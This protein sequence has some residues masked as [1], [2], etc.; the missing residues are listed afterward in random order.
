MILQ[1]RTSSWAQLNNKQTYR[2]TYWLFNVNL[3]KIWLIM[4]VIKMK[5]NVPHSIHK[6]DQDDQ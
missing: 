5:K 4:N 1:M 6:L 3:V 2:A